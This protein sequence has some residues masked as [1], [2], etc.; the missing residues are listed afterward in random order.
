MNEQGAEAKSGTVLIP[1]GTRLD[2][3]HIA[4][5]GM[6]GHISILAVRPP[7]VAVLATGDE[8]VAISETPAA[9]QIRNSNSHMLAALVRA[10]GCAVTVL[11]VARD[12]KEAL[13]PL[14]ENGLQHDTLIVSGGVSAGKYDL[15]KPMLLELGVKF[16]F[17][18]VRVNPG[19]QRRSACFQA[20]RCSDFPAIRA[21]ALSLI[22]YSR[23][24]RW[25]C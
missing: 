6:T 19:S 24:R 16:Y 23:G 10:T 20:S 22:S 11:P 4:T 18:R 3:S 15:V 2:A 8:I 13:R 12:T 21:P 25:N 14:L 17:E 5:A 9:H 1:Q 7:S